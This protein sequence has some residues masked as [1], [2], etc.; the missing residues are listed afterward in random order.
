MLSSNSLLSHNLK[1]FLSRPVPLNHLGEPTA[2]FI[3]ATN[4]II[5]TWEIFI[6]PAKAK[7]TRDNLNGFTTKFVNFKLSKDEKEEFESFM[8]HPADHLVEQLVVFISEGHKLSQS[9]D[10]KNKCFI[11][12]ATCKDEGSLN[13]D[14]CMTSRHPEWF[15]AVMMNVFKNNIMA[16][17]TPWMDLMESEDWG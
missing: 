11:A 4:R 2:H 5:Q 8:S 7:G 12:S 14:Y 3:R 17:G 16:K 9:W 13:H 15:P 1:S 6:M 10:D